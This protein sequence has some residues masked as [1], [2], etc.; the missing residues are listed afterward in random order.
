MQNTCHRLGNKSLKLYTLIL[1]TKITGS[2]EKLAKLRRLQAG[3]RNKCVVFRS[4]FRD[5]EQLTI[6]SNQITNL[7]VINLLAIRCLS[8]RNDISF[9]SVC[10]RTPGVPVSRGH[11]V[12]SQGQSHEN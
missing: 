4:C 11:F 8:F 10:W 3:V 5:L 12:V 1:F 6:L 7:L 9:P 2:I